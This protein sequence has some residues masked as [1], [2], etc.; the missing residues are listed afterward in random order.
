ML[1]FLNLAGTEICG[2]TKVHFLSET[3]NE[4]RISPTPDYRYQLDGSLLAKDL[5]HLLLA[6]IHI[7]AL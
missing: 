5:S 6:V 2:T 7:E 3:G 4:L 1:E